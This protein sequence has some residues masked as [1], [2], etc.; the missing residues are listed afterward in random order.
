MPILKARA[1][2]QQLF[3]HA[4]VIPDGWTPPFVEK[5]KEQASSDIKIVAVI[6]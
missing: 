1:K 6:V 2:R 4:V 5:T 3:A